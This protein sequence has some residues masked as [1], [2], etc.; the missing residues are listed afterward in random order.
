MLAWFIPATLLI[1]LFKSPWA[2]GE[3]LTTIATP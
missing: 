2:K 1:S 3:F